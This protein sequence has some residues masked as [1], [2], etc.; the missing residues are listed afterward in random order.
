MTGLFSEKSW[1]SVAANL[2]CK[3]DNVYLDISYRGVN[4]RY[5]ENLKMLLES[6][7]DPVQKRL[8]DKI[9][10]GSDFMINLM[11]IDSYSKYMQNFLSSSLCSVLMDKFCNKNPESFLFIR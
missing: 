3:Y 2:A 6:L 7:T 11:S 10:F 4:P 5:Y 1:R 8:E 9:I